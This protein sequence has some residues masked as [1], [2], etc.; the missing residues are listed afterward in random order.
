MLFDDNPSIKEPLWMSVA[1]AAVSRS[2]STLHV[3]RFRAPLFPVARFAPLLLAMAL[4]IV[5][6]RY[7]DQFDTSMWITLALGSATVSLLFL[8]RAGASSPAVFAAIVAIGGAWHHYRWND[9]PADDLS[10]SVTET[11]RPAW[12]RGSIREMLGLRGSEGFGPGAPERVSTRM[13]LEI[14]EISDGSRWSAA[15]G[16][17]L[18]IVAGDRTDVYAGQPVEV[19]GRLAKVPGPLNPG[20]FD[21]RSFLRS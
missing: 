9:Y 5:I 6:D 19:A 8:Y 3:K 4:G 20:E 10:W 16:R 7:A 18:M 12:V 15:S 17:A 13:I 1:A 21:Y 11:P 2:L 14:T